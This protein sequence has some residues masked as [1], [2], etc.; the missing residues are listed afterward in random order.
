[1]FYEI[2][3]NLTPNYTRDLI[4]LHQQSQYS[5]RKHDV[6][7]QIRART[8]KFKFTFYPHCLSEWNALETETRLAQSVAIFK[9][10]CYRKLAPLENPSMGFMTQKV[11]LI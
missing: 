7:G 5:L 1:M 9:K 2:V 10:K 8:E 6:I 11:C 4:P 3:K